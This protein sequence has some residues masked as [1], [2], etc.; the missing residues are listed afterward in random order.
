M[1]A[2]AAPSATA[3]EHARVLAYWTPARMAAAR[4]LDITPVRAGGVKGK[5]PG[6]PGGG[7]GGGGAATGASWTNGGPVVERTGKVWFHMPN[8]DYICS[9]SVITDSRSGY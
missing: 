2:A 7:G 3:V 1:P 6:P 9:G 8:G 5:P 4:P